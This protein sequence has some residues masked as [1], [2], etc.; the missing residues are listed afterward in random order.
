MLTTQTFTADGAKQIGVVHRRRDAPNFVATILAYGTWSS[1][2]I[3]YSLSPDGGTTKVPLKDL[4]GSAITSSAD[5]SVNVQLGNGSTNSDEISIWGTLSGSSSPS[6]T[7][8]F[9]DNR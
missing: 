7:I 6:I 5:D 1:G 2:T 3:A 8:S 4:T 9:Y